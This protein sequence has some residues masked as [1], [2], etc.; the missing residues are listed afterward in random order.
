MSKAPSPDFGEAL[1]AFRGGDL[2]RARALAESGVKAQPSPNWHHLLGLVLCRLGDAAAGVP[3]LEEAAKT[4]PGNAGFQI[5]LARALID[6]GRAAEVLAMPEPPPIA[7]PAALAMWQAR[8]EAADAVGDRS[9]ATAAWT[10]IATASPNDWRALSN[11]GNALAAQG[12]WIEASEALEA[13]L[14]LNPDE[15]AIR[16][17]ASAAFV[18]AGRKHQGKLQF[19][20]AER[21][22]RRAY[23][24]DPAN[25]ATVHLLGVALERMNRLDEV[26]SLVADAAAAAVPDDRLNYLRAMLARR[27][28][29]LE[30]AHA[31]LLAS[32]P[33]DEP[34]RRH[35]LH[36]KI[37][38]ALGNSDEAFDAAVAMNRAAFEQAVPAKGRAEWKRK[39]GEYRADLHA[40]ARMITP[41]W[42]AQVPRLEEPAGKRLSFL[43]GFPRSGTTLLDT[44]LM[45]HPDVAVLEEKQLVGR[46]ADV[47]GG[48]MGLE[49]A[50][51][52]L[53]RKARTA[54]FAALKEHAL[55]DFTGLVV[56]KFPLDMAAAPVIEAVFP[57]SPLIFAQRHPCDVVLS[58]FM[59]P[60]GVVNFSSIEDAADYYD[61]MMS[62]WTAAREAMDLKV[63]TIVYEDL[64]Q[65]PEAV[66][67]PLLAFLGLDWD[68]RLLD[69]RRTAKARGTIETPTYDQVT[70][71]ITTKASGRWKRYRKQLGPALPVL[72]PW[73]KRLGYRD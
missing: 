37:A 50:S 58:G 62:I 52:S 59:Q 69:H 26:E 42:A 6:A 10:H 32:D 14:K 38:D 23:E 2:D 28:G 70:E 55:G 16:A 68:D 3:H 56:D 13:A 29:D 8:A 34:I 41:E 47:V 64:V 24:L 22:F 21:A 45:G 17:A 51:S 39:A 18:E 71:P 27:R 40:L 66:L 4:D 12:K 46:A 57:R 1:E 65:D 36:A 60:I 33:Q 25:P 30:S 7:S 49:K 53:L 11:L 67:R 31:V 15:G 48:S 9:A 44:F 43:L 63:H 20:E 72:L 19:D 54:Y 61:A 73:A 35:A 5:M